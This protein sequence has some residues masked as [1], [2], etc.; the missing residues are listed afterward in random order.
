[1]KKII[2]IVL[3]SLICLIIGGV[4]FLY[5]SNPTAFKAQGQTNVQGQ[6]KTAASPS[7][8]SELKKTVA[9]SLGDAIITNIKDSK[10][11]LKIKIAL[12]IKDEKCKSYFEKS[13]SKI[14]DTIISVLRNKNE[15]DLIAPDSQQSIKNDIK[16]ALE[17]KIETKDLVDIYIDE[18]VIQ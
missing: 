17:S 11:Y 7:P 13:T 18:F 12:E 10:K 4:A 16:E 14:K 3:V 5:F 1:M 6:T 15:I 8:S 9:L 2:T